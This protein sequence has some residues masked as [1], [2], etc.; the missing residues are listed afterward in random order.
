MSCLGKELL[1]ESGGSGNFS[2]TQTQREFASNRLDRSQQPTNPGTEA[3]KG[4]WI[5]RISK[6]F[7]W[8]KRIFTAKTRSVFKYNAYA[9]ARCDALWD[10]HVLEPDWDRSSI[11]QPHTTRPA[12]TH[13]SVVA[14]DFAL[15]SA[16]V[17]V[18]RHCNIFV[19]VREPNFP[20]FSALPSVKRRFNNLRKYNSRGR[21]KIAT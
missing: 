13:T 2:H 6:K 20:L 1:R 17:L 9:N 3:K 12:A 21:S 14:P 15:F 18:K 11:F 19:S 8:I 16:P 4:S 10:H 5:L 7:H